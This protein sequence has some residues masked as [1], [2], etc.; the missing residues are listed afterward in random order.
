MFFPAFD[1]KAVAEH[2]G[3]FAVL[4]GAA[5]TIWTNINS[6][7]KSVK[8]LLNLAPQVSVLTTQVDEI[9]KELSPNGGGSL[10]DAVTEIRRN[11]STI[12]HNQ[13]MIVDFQGQVL[14]EFDA[15]GD[16]THISAKGVEILGCESHEYLN[17]GWLN[18]IRQR[19][20]DVW[21]EWTDAV[22]TESSWRRE[23]QL[24]GSPY[25]IE[26]ICT[27]DN[28]QRVT[29]WLGTLAPIA[30]SMPTVVRSSTS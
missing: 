16:C 21:A 6:M 30:L 13:K 8:A 27:R 5:Y 18:F 23:I 22:K 19:D 29:G 25:M 12:R 14:F 9:K 11:V 2:W 24:N 20:L 15:D 26:I 17:H 28:H 4:C 3:S 1:L 7:H 10:K